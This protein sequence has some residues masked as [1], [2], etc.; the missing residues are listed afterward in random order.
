MNL[1]VNL[2]KRVM[3]T[4][5]LRYYPVVESSNGRI[6]PDWVS[7]DG[8]EERHSEGAYYI[9]WRADGKRKRLSVGKDAAQA[10]A[11]RLRQQ[12]E[13]N[14]VAN[15]VSV[16][17]SSDGADAKG[18][19]LET[20]IADFIEE[21]RLTKKKKTLYAYTKATEYFAESCHK[22]YLEDIER[23]DM[24]KFAAFLRDEKELSPRTCRNVF[25]NVMTF[26]KAQGVRG[27][28]NKGDWPRFVQTEVEIYEK[29][30]LAKLYAASD[31]K[32]KLWWDFFLMTGLREQETM[33]MT[34]RDVNCV[35]GTISVRWKP[36]YGWT[37]KAYKERTVPIPTKL[38]D[39]LKK[40]KTKAGADCPLLFPTSGC[41]PKLNFLDDLK[42]AAKRAKLNPDNFYLHKFRATFAT[43]HLWAGVDLRTVQSWLGH[44]DME[45]TLRY[46]KPS[47]GQAVR[48]KVDATF[49]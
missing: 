21:T 24:L 22:R 32:E 6:K 26:L 30:D 4:E 27:V 15:G 35:Q 29:E 40:A 20:A 36:K 34:W 5:G 9:E 43:W 3:T 42:A 47:R 25:G 39:E 7:V 12:A 23:I 48:D 46:L 1:R 45:S 8:K 28:A 14:A 18:R 41:K 19:L 38:Q 13:L 49:V 37:P 10:Q 31:S 16:L 33:Y 11:R 2:T 44:S 17:P